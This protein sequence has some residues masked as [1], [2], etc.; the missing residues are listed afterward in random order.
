M[1]VMLLSSLTWKWLFKCQ[2]SAVAKASINLNAHCKARFSH[3]DEECVHLME[4]SCPIY[5]VKVKNSN[6]NFITDS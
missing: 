6:Q 5:L 3:S 1:Q 2:F 4:Q